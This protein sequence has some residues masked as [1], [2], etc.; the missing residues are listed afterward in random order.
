M[1]TVILAGGLAKRLRPLTYD[2]PK[3]LVKIN[4]TPFI[5]YQIKYLSNQGIRKILLCIGY[6]GDHIK[7]YIGNGSRYGIKI[8]YSEDGKNLLGTGGS[9]F[10]A[11][12]SLDDNFMV[13]YG[14]SYLPINFSQVI[15]KFNHTE[16]KALMVIMRNNNQ[17][18]KS[19]VIFNGSNLIEYNKNDHKE[20]MKYIDY[21]VSL[22]KKS[23]FLEFS[24]KQG[25][26][27][28]LSKYLNELSLKNNLDYYL[29]KERFYE[30]GSKI[31]IESF[32]N[33]IKG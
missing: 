4:G 13:L 33:F 24:K 14:D 11:R 8:T 15:K 16:K 23:F 7:N 27:F 9:I 31:G 22:Y 20:S 6:L 1:Q 5:D 25:K 32:T 29:V 18:D 3:C 2:I 30:I 21:G 28:D 26:N 10:N 12:E 17:W 19:N